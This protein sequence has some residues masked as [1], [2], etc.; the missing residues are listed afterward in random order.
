MRTGTSGQMS[1]SLYFPSAAYLPNGMSLFINNEKILEQ[2]FATVGET[3]INAYYEPNQD[4][5]VEIVMDKALI[6][7]NAG[8]GQDQRELSVII[9][10]L[11]FE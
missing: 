11:K 1:G 3:T 5:I 2:Q 6:P 10:T 7:K 4:V 9:G 8:L